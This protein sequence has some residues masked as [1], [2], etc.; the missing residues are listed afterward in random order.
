MLSKIFKTQNSKLKTLKN[1][2]DIVIIGAG[3]AGYVAAIRAGQVGLK[4]AIIE[5]D[6]PMSAFSDYSNNRARFAETFHSILNIAVYDSN[7]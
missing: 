2:Y 6:K 4:T 5:K 7:L 1:M 3:P